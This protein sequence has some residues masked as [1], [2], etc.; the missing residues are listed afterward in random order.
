MYVFLPH[1]QDS[2][3]KTN[4]INARQPGAGPW[5]EEAVINRTEQNSEQSFDQLDLVSGLPR[6]AT[7]WLEE[8]AVFLF[9]I[10][11]TQVYSGETMAAQHRPLKARSWQVHKAIVWIYFDFRM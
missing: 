9:L 8:E 7:P 1:L 2:F 5:I 10:Q 3:F 4:E 6:N 11:P